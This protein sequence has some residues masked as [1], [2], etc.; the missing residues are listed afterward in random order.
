MKTGEEVRT[1]RRD[2]DRKGGTGQGRRGG[3]GKG[4]KE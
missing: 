1:G 2:K 3:E 4:V